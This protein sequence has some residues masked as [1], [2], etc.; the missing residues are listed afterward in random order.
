MSHSTHRS[1]V[2]IGA[3]A[4]G[5]TAASIL[6]QA[7]H[8]VVV[9]EARDRIGGRL[10][11]APA[12]EGSLDLGATWF[13]DDERH[14]RA[15]LADAGLGSF[16][17]HTTGDAVYQDAGGVQRLAGN[18]IDARSH[19]FATGAAALTDT[20]AA[21]LP[22]G[23]LRLNTP[24][25][26]I[27]AGETEGSGLTV[28]TPDSV[29]EAE[30]VVLAVPPALALARIDFDGQLPADLVRVAEQTPVWMGAVVKVVAEYADAFWRRDG[31]AGAAFSRSGPLQEI[32]DMSGPD[33]WPAALFGFAHASTARGAGPDFPTAVTGQLTQL[34]GPQAA[35]PL[36][37]HVQDWSAEQWTSP[38]QVAQLT[39]YSFFSHRLYQR[40]AL[41]GRLHW[42]STETARG[43]AGHIEGAL[44]GGERAA[45]A[46]LHALPDPNPEPAAANSTAV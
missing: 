27:R 29:I 18:P 42:A 44:Q 7:G 32:H 26:A 39:D 6:T 24:V 31:L 12:A 13:W 25:T 1:V 30:H 22:S 43:Y 14:V 46:I 23:T 38:A 45:H 35:R 41:D 11:S 15:L 4:S 8:D 2:V 21:S 19:R 33:G 34:F 28:H 20:L 10:L 16:V 5:L 40:P 36:A 3:G 9:L 17:Q 37:L